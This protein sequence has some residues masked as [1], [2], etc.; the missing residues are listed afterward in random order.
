MSQDAHPFECPQAWLPA[1]CDVGVIG[2]HR[3]FWR[4]SLTGARQAIRHIPN[5]V[6]E[7][8]NLRDYFNIENLRQPAISRSRAARSPLG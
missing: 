7:L 5:A 3:S 1:L 2:P 4:R 6:D 8:E